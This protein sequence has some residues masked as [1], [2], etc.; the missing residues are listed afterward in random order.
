M[1]LQ[2][3]YYYLLFTEQNFCRLQRGISK[4]IPSIFNINEKTSK[5][6]SRPH[7]TF[8]DIFCHFSKVL[9]MSFIFR[10]STVKESLHQGKTKPFCG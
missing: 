4:I 9:N 1:S 6:A 2:L 8:P 10:L 3:T 5:Q 7:L